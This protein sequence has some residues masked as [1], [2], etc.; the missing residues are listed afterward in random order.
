MSCFKSTSAT[1][2]TDL[3]GLPGCPGCEVVE[4][5]GIWS[6]FGGAGC[7]PPLLQNFLHRLADYAEMIEFSLCFY[8]FLC[9]SA[10][11]DYSWQRSVS[12]QNSPLIA[13][14]A[15]ASLMESTAH[16]CSQPWQLKL[17]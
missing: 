4:M 8:A 6:C 12:E 2:D 10:A 16:L 5:I 3:R 1:V 14:L 11:W 13:V 7:L 9:R 17:R 15:F